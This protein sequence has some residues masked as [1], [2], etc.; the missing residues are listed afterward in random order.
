MTSYR[1]CSGTCAQ[2]MK[3]EKNWQDGRGSN[4][5]P[6]VLETTALPIELPSYLYNKWWLPSE[7]N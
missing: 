7:S 5:R 1:S 2:A 4:S 3:V 6:L